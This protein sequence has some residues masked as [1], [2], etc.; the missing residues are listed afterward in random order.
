MSRDQLVRAVFAALD[1][2]KDGVLNQKD[3]LRGMRVFAEATGMRGGSAQACD[4]AELTR[5][6]VFFLKLVNDKS[7]DAGCFCTDEDQEL[8]TI[9]AKLSAQSAAVAKAVSK[10]VSAARPPAMSPPPAMSR[11]EL[12]SAIFQRLDVDKD[13]KLNPG[14]MRRFAEQQDFDGTDE[15]WA[16]AY[17]E[18]CTEKGRDPA[19][20]VN[21]ELFTQLLNDESEEGHRLPLHRRG[22]A[23][24]A[25]EAS[26]QLRSLSQPQGRLPARKAAGLLRWPRR[27][28]A[29]PGYAV[30]AARASPGWP[31]VVSP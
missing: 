10:A 4:N 19:Q 3:H 26:R 8:R 5:D 12:I 11:T 6:V 31:G 17:K 22:D 28:G 24:D 1:A 2:D 23:V 21:L 14:E 29:A 30:A 25:R 15:E 16:E 20:G 7:G 13:G 9:Q 18:L 27:W